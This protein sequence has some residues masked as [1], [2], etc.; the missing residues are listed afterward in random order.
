MRRWPHRLYTPAQLSALFRNAG[1]GVETLCD[2]DGK[3]FTRGS[4][5]LV[6]VGRKPR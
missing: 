1:L 2:R 4:P 3:P 6:I 5:R